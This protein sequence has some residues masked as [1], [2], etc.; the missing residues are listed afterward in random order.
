MDT[1]ATTIKSE[2][3]LAPAVSTLL[4]RFYIA[5]QVLATSEQD[6]LDPF[7]SSASSELCNSEH[8]PYGCD[9]TVSSLGMRLWGYQLGAQF[10]L[11]DLV[12]EHLP[13]PLKHSARRFLPWDDPQELVEKLEENGAKPS[14]CFRTRA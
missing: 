7:L 3:S 11:Q 9:E 4:E 10:S 5:E 1:T 8:S 12:V 6:K 13:I 14:C 2:S